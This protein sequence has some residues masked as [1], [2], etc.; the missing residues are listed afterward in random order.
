MAFG[1]QLLDLTLEYR[2]STE[3]KAASRA[4]EEISAEYEQVILRLLAPDLADIA[5]EHGNV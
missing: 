3:G 4:P 5:P 1:K 2:D